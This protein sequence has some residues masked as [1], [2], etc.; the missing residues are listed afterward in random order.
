MRWITVR[1]VGQPGTSIVPEPP[2]ADPG[3]IRFDSSLRSAGSRIVRWHPLN[4]RATALTWAPNE[5]MRRHV[6][7]AFVVVMPVRL[8]VGRWTLAI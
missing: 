3:V 6:L 4:R 2:F 1:P 7:V 5:E 8:G